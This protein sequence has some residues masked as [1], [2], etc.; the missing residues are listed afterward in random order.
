M[1]R[2]QVTSLLSFK[3]GTQNQESG[4]QCQLPHWK[5]LLCKSPHFS[6]SVYQKELAEVSNT[7]FC[8]HYIFFLVMMWILRSCFYIFHRY[9]QPKGK[10]Y[11][12]LIALKTQRSKH[13]YVKL[14][15]SEKIS[16][17]G[18]FKSSRFYRS[19][20]ETSLRC[21]GDKREVKENMGL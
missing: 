3:Y 8:Y 19:A 21:K 16:V 12:L 7:F 17:L 15:S 9:T 10:L 20:H 13:Y 6:Q 11:C 14:K 1:V 18:E 2:T 4:C 5:I